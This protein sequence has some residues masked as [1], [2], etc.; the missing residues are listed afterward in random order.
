MVIK[1]LRAAPPKD[2]RKDA[3]V[4]HVL[5]HHPDAVPDRKRK[6][7]THSEFIL[8]ACKQIRAKK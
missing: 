6:H 5:R 8:E 1:D 3:L 4:R 7:Q 2:K